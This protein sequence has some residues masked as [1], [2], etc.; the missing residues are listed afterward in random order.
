MPSP[1]KIIF[2]GTPVFAVS[3][4]DILVKNDFDIVAVVTAPEKPSG[5]GQKIIPSP[6][7]EYAEQKGLKILQP[8]NLKD[9][10]FILE[11]RHL[12]ADLQVVVAFRMMPEVVWKMPKLG[13]FNLHASLLPQYR[14]SA[15][16]NWAIINGEKETGVTTF[17]LQ[18][19][20][21]TGKILFQEKIPVDENET[22]GE[23]HDRIMKLGAALVLK[24]TVSISKENFK[25]T[26]QDSLTKGLTLK[27]APKLNK[28]NCRIDVRKTAVEI[29]N[30]VRGLCPTP[31]ATVEFYN[32]NGFSLIAKIFVVKPENGHHQN[33]PGLI[34]TDNKTYL[35]IFLR[36]GWIFV[37]ELQ[38][39]G[40]NR[41][42][43]KDLLNGFKFTGNWVAQ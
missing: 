43:I 33:K 36:D 7:K 39:S 32:D 38:V 27:T 10:N 9:E 29:F 34:E 41:M 21:D 3:S 22:A 19:E 5:R 4:L 37:N 16:I 1:L 42:A 17:F 35:K 30:L 26:E 2:F 25:L 15:P 18:Q 6:V 12:K 11:L 23:L 20:I 8:S 13:T 24:T 14:G 28:T 31:T 40:K